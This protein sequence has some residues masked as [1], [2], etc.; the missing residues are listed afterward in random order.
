MAKNSSSRTIRARTRSTFEALMALLVLFNYFLVIF[1]LT[2]IPLRDFWLQGRFQ[3]TLLRFNEPITI[4]PIS[5]QEVKLP[6]GK[7]LQVP[8]VTALSRYDAVKGI[9][10]YRSTSNYLETVDRLQRAIE[11]SAPPREVDDILVALRR[12]SSSMIDT[13]PFQVANKTGTLE[14]IKNL[15]RERVFGTENASAKQ[16]FNI[17]WS[18]DYLTK[19]GFAGELG[20]FNHNIRPLIETNYFRPIGEDGRPIDNF[21]AIDFFFGI[22]FFL[23]FLTRTWWISRT[24]VGL[25]WFEAMLWRWYDVFLFIPF[26]RWL[27]IIPTLIRLHQAK[28]INLNTI[29][30]QTIRGF[31][32]TISEE[33]TES[34]VIRV[35]NQIQGYVRRGEVRNFLIRQKNREFVDL[36]DTNEIAEIVKLVITVMVDKVLPRIQPEAEAL[37]KYNIDKALASTPAYQSLQNL[38][39]MK[40]LETRLSDRVSRQLYQAFIDVSRE[41]SRED[42]AAE[43][44]IEKLTER[45]TREMGTELQ[46]RNSIDRLE[47][48]IIA[49]LEEI[50]LNYVRQITDE[51]IEVILEQTRELRRNQTNTPRL[52]PV[53]YRRE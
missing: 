37:I 24:H 50:K 35:L 51:D 16:A 15:M 7:P 20:F 23:E 22:I 47:N 48:L 3:V 17:F 25:R 38:P 39:G 26:F 44:L 52:E 29:R 2:Y 27:R 46:T 10:P 49:L 5:F 14:K 8:F 45:F 34:I 41:L 30:E 32:A 42:K 21:E 36:N 11:S 43:Q 13:N 31:V 6:P 12:D 19:E 53:R 18:R 40:D 4:G 33:I 1:D 28:L 9:Q